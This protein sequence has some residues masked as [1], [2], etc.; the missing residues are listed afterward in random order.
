MQQVQLMQMQMPATA[1]GRGLSRVHDRVL[2][3]LLPTAAAKRSS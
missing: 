2:L 1:K 3:V